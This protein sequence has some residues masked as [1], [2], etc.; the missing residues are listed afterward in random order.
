MFAA[1][2][3]AKYERNINE[4]HGHT[5][6]K[7]LINHNNN[8]PP[9]GPYGIRHGTSNHSIQYSM[10][11]FYDSLQSCRPVLTSSRARG[12]VPAYPNLPGF[13][14]VEWWDGNLDRNIIT[15]DFCHPKFMPWGGFEKAICTTITHTLFTHTPAL[16]PV[17]LG[18]Y[19]RV[20]PTRPFCNAKLQLIKLTHRQEIVCAHTFVESNDNDRNR[21][22]NIVRYPTKKYIYKRTVFCDAGPLKSSVKIP[23]CNLLHDLLVLSVLI[24]F[25]SLCLVFA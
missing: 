11:D 16:E 18:Q 6:S 23:K 9:S 2:N 3:T 1:P 8:L 7:H 12:F 5:F 20:I 14:E 10:C 21:R 25:W 22:M 4:Q 24:L 13:N 17:K 15:D 19:R